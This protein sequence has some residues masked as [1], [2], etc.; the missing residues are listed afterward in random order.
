MG[1]GGRAAALAVTVAAGLAATGMAGCGAEEA[2]AEKV[3]EE[4]AE[5]AV[6]AGSDGDV[7]VDMDRDGGEVRVEGEDGSLVMGADELPES[8]PDDV[9]LPEADHEVLSAMEVTGEEGHVQVQLAVGSGTSLADLAAHV[10]SGLDEAG[11]EVTGNTT[12][13]S[14]DLEMVRMQF[15]GHGREGLISARTV[16]GELTATYLVGDQDEQ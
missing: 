7:E 2:L 5:A 13:T 6:G 10:E 9:P 14:G 11:Y 8:F 15:A 1:R 3:A 16:D 12:Q 4:G